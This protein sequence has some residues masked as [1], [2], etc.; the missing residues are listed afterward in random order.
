MVAARSLDLVDFQVNKKNGSGWDNSAN[1][2]VLLLHAGPKPMNFLID[3][4]EEASF[5][6]LSLD[7]MKSGFPEQ[8][9][10]GVAQDGNVALMVV[11][12]SATAPEVVH[13]LLHHVRKELAN[14]AVRILLVGDFP[15]ERKIPAPY[16]QLD[17][18][19]MDQESHEVESRLK[20]AVLDLGRL[21]LQLRTAENQQAGLEDILQASA[22]LLGL[23]DLNRFCQ[24]V[25]NELKTLFPTTDK[26]LICSL[27][28]R[29]YSPDS[30]PII[31]AATENFDLASGKAT[32]EQDE[33]DM[34][35]SSR[36]GA[37]R[38]DRIHQSIATG[39]HCYFDNAA[40][41]FMSSGKLFKC[42]LYVEF[43]AP[44]TWPDRRRLELLCRTVSVGFENAGLFD[45]IRQLAFYDSMT[46]LGNRAKFREEI[47]QRIDQGQGHASVS[48]AVI[49]IVLD[50]LPELN[51]A[52]GHTAGDQFL[53]SLAQN[54]REVFPEAYSI[55][56]T[57][58]DGFGLCVPFH[59]AR[60]KKLL[61]AKINHL[62]DYHL[63]EKLNLPHLTPRMGISR[64]PD[65]G[66]TA[67]D[68]W[69]NSSIA[70]AD[71]KEK[72]G[73]NYGYYDD[74]IETEINDRVRM[75]TAL[76]KGLGDGSLSLRYQPQID[77][78]TNRMIGVEALIRW[79][80][81]D[82]DFVPPAD[83]IP[84]AERSGLITPV[85]EWVLNEACM[86]RKAWTDQ[87]VPGFRVAV[88]LS[89]SQFQSD[90][91]VSLIEQVLER[92]GCPA[93]FLE[94][95]ITESVIMEDPD[96]AVRNFLALGRSGV[97]FSIDD[98]G[99]GYSSLSYL[100]QL[101]VSVLKID[102]GFIDHITHN[103]EDAAITRT[104]IQLGRSLGMRVL[105]EGV[106]SP[107]Q[108]DF[109]KEA[110]CHEAQGYF[111]SKPVRAEEIPDF[112]R[113]Y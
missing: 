87:G 23:R 10:T 60:E 100:R 8:L 99:T 97:G 102:K 17:V 55:A 43:S 83:F 47:Q 69:K 112:V 28:L 95:E 92:T 16:A 19:L 53:T 26:A 27:D 77:L 74:R 29:K 24:G 13:I 71:L 67:A 31:I 34:S 49:Q 111:F 40:A 15:D 5:T 109:L 89:L 48:F 33:Q 110:D 78:R 4:L 86:Q 93:H 65:D 25:L 105:A 106:E 18:S 94:L 3:G 41:L 113:K 22:R 32:A 76:K 45:E 12:V 38:Y 20:E 88:N 59:G 35:G 52:L 11:H 101:P 84:V 73:N 107:E 50:H 51:I 75:N 62:F 96:R 36:L 80:G 57:S 9:E 66:E 85:S 98:F 72:G 81:E 39:Q 79:Q 14:N 58:G 91:I 68:L 61:P 44:V 82:G 6:S 63:A 64:Y 103:S 37:V 1:R 46:G 42:V 30:D 54:I 108:I 7:D 21:F 2:Q 56:R 104:I 70:L 90:E